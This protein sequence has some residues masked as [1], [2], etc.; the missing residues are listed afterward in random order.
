MEVCKK[1]GAQVAND[2]NFYS[3]CGA[4]VKDVRTE[5]FKVSADGLVKMV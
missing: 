2:T 5:E 3:A 1:C 4:S